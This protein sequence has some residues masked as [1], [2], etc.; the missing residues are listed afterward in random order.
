MHPSV[1]AGV[2]LYGGLK[3]IR[4]TLALEEAIEV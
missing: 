2:F 1:I 4:T 3:R